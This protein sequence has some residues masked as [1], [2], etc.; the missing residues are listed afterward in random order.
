MEKYGIEKNRIKACGIGTYSFLRETYD[1]VNASSIAGALKLGKKTMLFASHYQIRSQL[2]EI[3]RI[4][5]II[6]KRKDITLLIKPHLHDFSISKSVLKK[7]YKKAR[8]IQNMSFYECLKVSD[9]VLTR[10]S[11]SCSFDAMMFDKPC[12]IFKSKGRFFCNVGGNLEFN[13]K[14]STFIEIEDLT[15]LDNDLLDKILFDEKYRFNLLK[16]QKK[17]FSAYS[18]LEYTKEVVKNVKTILNG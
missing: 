16:K 11:T 9:L 3:D 18:R 13:K 5:S 1:A 7:R 17:W 10:Y 2:H 4:Y 15:K 6:S 14:G 8:V 12:I